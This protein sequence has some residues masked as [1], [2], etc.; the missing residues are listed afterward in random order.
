MEIVT[1]SKALEIH[2]ILALL[3]KLHWIWA[4]NK[5]VVIIFNHRRQESECCNCFVRTFGN[6]IF[7][8]VM[9][10]DDSRV[11]ASADQILHQFLS[12]FLDQ[13]SCKSA[14]LSNFHFE[15]GQFELFIYNSVILKHLILH[16]Y[17]LLICGGSIC[18]CCLSGYYIQW[19][20]RDNGN[21][22]WRTLLKNKQFS[23]TSWITLKETNGV[24]GAPRFYSV[25]SSIQYSAVDDFSNLQTNTKFHFSGW[26][27]VNMLTLG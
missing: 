2:S 13:G 3:K 19:R 20:R 8:T 4:R 14:K 23:V 15:K 1:V 10:E 17:S 18:V 22:H 11:Q 25:R 24:I 26:N 27:K 9:H 5:C 21:Q 16:I 6:I 12:S 7:S